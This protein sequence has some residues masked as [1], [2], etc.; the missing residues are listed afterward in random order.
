LLVDVYEDHFV[1]DRNR[2][3]RDREA[4]RIFRIE[5]GSHVKGPAVG[6][7]NDDAIGEIP[8][9]EWEAGM[10]AMIFHC[11]DMLADAVEADLD[12]SDVDK[13]SAI[14][15]DFVD[16]CGAHERHD[17]LLARIAVD[18]KNERSSMHHVDD[19]NHAARDGRPRN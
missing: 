15:G 14:L 2:E 1:F 12:P 17:M 3:A 13:Q 19:Q 18:V 5:S 10:R 11:I 7:A 9:R 6:L 8:S 4:V 16:A